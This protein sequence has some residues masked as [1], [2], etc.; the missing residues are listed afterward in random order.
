MTKTPIQSKTLWF[1]ILTIVAMVLTALMADES[2]R[3]FIGSKA[4]ILVMAT[5]VVN[6][7]LRFQTSTAIS[8]PRANET[9]ATPKRKDSPLDVLKEEF[10]NSDSF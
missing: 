9:T 2:F 5:N 10:G 6:V 3:E 8:I 1:N 4:I 7:I